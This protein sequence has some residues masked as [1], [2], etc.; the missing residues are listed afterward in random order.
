[1]NRL[2]TAG[3][4][5]ALALGCAPAWAQDAGQAIDEEADFLTAMDEEL[6]SSPVSSLMMEVSSASTLMVPAS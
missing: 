2:C 5:T 1:M 3:L 6:T 4:L